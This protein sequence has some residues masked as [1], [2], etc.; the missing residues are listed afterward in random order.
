MNLTPL[1]KRAKN[2]ALYGWRSHGHLTVSSQGNLMGQQ[3]ILPLLTPAKR[4]GIK[5][6]QNEW[7]SKGFK[8]PSGLEDLKNLY[9]KAEYMTEAT[10]AS[11]KLLRSSSGPYMTREKETILSTNDPIV[12]KDDNSVNF[13]RISSI[14]FAHGA[15]SN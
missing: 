14:N 3:V 11:K 7:N 8:Y 5:S 1:I 2:T 12:Y 6:R 15:P 9:S 4:H 10:V 13:R